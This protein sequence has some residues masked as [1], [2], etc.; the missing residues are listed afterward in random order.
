MVNMK[1]T[2]AGLLEKLGL[3]LDKND[4]RACLSFMREHA[5]VKPV[6]SAKRFL[7]SKGLLK[8]EPDKPKTEIDF[9]KL[10]L[11]NLDRPSM[12]A[13]AF[14]L[15][16]AGV[17]VD[18]P[19]DADGMPRIKGLEDHALLAK[20]HAA[21]AALPTPE[22]LKALAELDPTKLQEV[23]KHDCL[24]IMID[25]R[26]AECQVCPDKGEC[27]K[28]FVKNLRGNFRVFK[29][30][31]EAI[32]TEEQARAVSADV[33]AAADDVAPRKIR[34][35]KWKANMPLVVFTIDNPI[36][37]TPDQAFPRRV[38]GAVIKMAK[39]QPLAVTTMS[40]VLRVTQEYGEFTEDSFVEELL[41]N[42]RRGG[43]IK[44]VD[45]LTPK[46]KKLY[47]AAIAAES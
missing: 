13:L 26:T 2:L 34:T 10:D 22:N 14:D 33:V 47:D 42:L 24:G 7:R 8:R 45:D 29:E 39:K 44:L 17:K 46:E 20:L 21:I 16:K 38:F 11:R 4:R 12:K 31:R 6:K 40:R 3:T 25:L 28:Q 41:P 15:H 37:T 27:A 1:E 30:A 36:D 9:K 35:V 32:K 18:L 43:V 19:F 5:D 23:L